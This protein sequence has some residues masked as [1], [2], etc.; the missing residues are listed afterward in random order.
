MGAGQRSHGACFASADRVTRELAPRVGHLA[1]GT[2]RVKIQPGGTL[3]DPKSNSALAVER[4]M[5]LGVE[6]SGGAQNRTAD[7]GI[8]R[9]SL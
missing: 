3:R 9:P 2:G 5:F 4:R 6:I 1:D 7:L 8:M